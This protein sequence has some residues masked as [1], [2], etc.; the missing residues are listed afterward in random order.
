MKINKQNAYHVNHKWKDTHNC[1]ACGNHG[2]GTVIYSTCMF[3]LHLWVGGDSRGDRD[4]INNGW[5]GRRLL[6]L[7][8]SYGKMKER[9]IHPEEGKILFSEQTFHNNKITIP[10]FGKILLGN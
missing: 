1:L 4:P 3:I 8:N 9:N 7:G 2:I 6:G 10:N 5:W